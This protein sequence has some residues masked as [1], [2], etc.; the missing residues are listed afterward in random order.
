MSYLGGIVTAINGHEETPEGSP[1]MAQKHVT[2]IRIDTITDR[3]VIAEISDHADTLREI[4]EDDPSMS[5]FQSRNAIPGVIYDLLIVLYSHDLG[6]DPF[7]APICGSDPAYVGAAGLCDW[8]DG[9]ALPESDLQLTLHVDIATDIAVDLRDPR[10]LLVLGGWEGGALPTLH[11]RIHGPV[12]PSAPTVQHVL[13]GVAA[14]LSE[15]VECVIQRV[16][17]VQELG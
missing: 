14:L 11:S 6:S 1:T 13:D 16:R 10:E 4:Y 15:A 17:V 2:A 9:V 8:D 7:I 12:A 5:E 3:S